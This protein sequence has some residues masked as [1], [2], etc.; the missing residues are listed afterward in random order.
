M[1]VHATLTHMHVHATL[2]TYALRKHIYTF[3]DILLLACDIPK[4][5]RPQNMIPLHIQ[6]NTSL[7][8]VTSCIHGR[9]E[10]FHQHQTHLCISIQP[11]IWRKMFTIYLHATLI[12]NG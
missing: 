6:T 5:M 1:H 10:L 12:R 3:Q 2:T 8:Y 11:S 7:A 4:L 9:H